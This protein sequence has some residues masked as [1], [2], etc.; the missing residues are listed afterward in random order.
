LAR[1]YADLDL[2]VNSKERRSLSEL[3]VKLGY[4]PDKIFNGLHG[5]Q[6]LYFD[7]M[8]HRRHVDVFVDAVRM[9]HV[10]ELKERIGLRADI[11]TPSDLL[12]TKLQIVEL[13]AKDLLDLLSLLHDQEVVAGSNDA[14][15][16][17]YLGKLWGADWP[18]WRTSKMTLGKVRDSVAGIL[19]AE[20]QERVL[21]KVTAL[22]KVLEDCPKGF[23]WKV[24]ARL[25]DRVKWYELP[26]EV[27]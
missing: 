10:I 14:F 5:H 19:P 18:I 1:T 15:D 27:K 9:C 3:M 11:L 7:D 22:E 2:A 6:R 25:G 4:V 16:S 20:G 13:N 26:E 17:T 8:E 12:L 21:A 23:G 24:R